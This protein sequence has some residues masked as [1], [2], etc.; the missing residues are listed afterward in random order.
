MHNYR[1]QCIKDIPIHLKATFLVLR[2]RHY[3]YT[4]DKKFYKKLDFL[5]TYYRINN[6]MLTLL[7]NYPI[8]IV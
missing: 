6:R 5:P 8:T 4:C 7:I 3:V 1:Y 2:K